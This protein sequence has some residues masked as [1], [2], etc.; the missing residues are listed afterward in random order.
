MSS[1]LANLMS[2]CI[3]RSETNRDFLLLFLKSNTKSRGQRL[4]PNVKALH[5]SCSPCALHA[6]RVIYNTASTTSLG[7]RRTFLQTGTYCHAFRWCSSDPAGGCLKRLYPWGFDTEVGLPEQFL[8][9]IINFTALCQGRQFPHNPMGR[10]IYCGE[11]SYRCWCSC[12]ALSER[13]GPGRRL[14]GS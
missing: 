1:G 3:S 13:H 5:M 9:T 4:H 7:S 14:F 10:F 6:E 2:M 12:A 11:T 8:A